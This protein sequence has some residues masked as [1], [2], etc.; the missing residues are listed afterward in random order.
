MR[1]LMWRKVSRI[2]RFTRFRA[3]AFPTFFEAMI[4]NLFL[5]NPLGMEKMMH[6]R[7]TRF[8]FSFVHHLFKLRPL[9]QSFGFFERKFSHL[10]GFSVT[11]DS[12][13]NYFC[14]PTQELSRLLAPRRVGGKTP[15]LDRQ[16][17]SAFTSAVCQYASSPNGRA[18]FAEAVHTFSFDITGLKSPFHKSILKKILKNARI[19]PYSH[20]IRW[21]CNLG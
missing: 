13:C 7:P 12:V 20:Q 18:S 1:C 3:T 16:A 15:Q 9:G 17:F 8:F 21:L 5:P 2:L 19:P 14:W 11:L 10:L 4:P 6:S